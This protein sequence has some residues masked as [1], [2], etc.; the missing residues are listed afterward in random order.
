MTAF[1]LLQGSRCISWPNS[2]ATDSHQCDVG[3]QAQMALPN[4]IAA[5]HLYC[6]QGIA[7]STQQTYRSGKK[8]FLCQV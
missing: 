4:L 3:P 1:F 7:E 5:V 2:S 6:K 8:F